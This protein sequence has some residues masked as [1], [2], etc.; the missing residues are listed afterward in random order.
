[1][2]DGKGWRP[3]GPCRVTADM[4][5]RKLAKGFLPFGMREKLP[6]QRDMKVRE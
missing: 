3:E 1:M 6:D 4:Q 2:Q 5:G